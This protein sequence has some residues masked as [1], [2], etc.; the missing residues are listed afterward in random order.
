MAEPGSRNVPFGLGVPSLLLGISAFVLSVV[1]FVLGGFA[2]ASTASLPLGGLGFLLGLG[3]LAVSIMH[4]GH[5]IGF[6]LAGLACNLSALVTALIGI[7]GLGNAHLKT[8]GV[9]PFKHEKALALNQED[10]GPNSGKRGEAVASPAKTK[11]AEVKDPDWIDASNGPFAY[12]DISVKVGMVLVNSVTIKDVLGQQ[13][14]T[15]QKYLGIQLFIGNAGKTKKINYRGWAGVV[16]AGDLTDLL[17]SAGK[18]GGGIGDVIGLS[19]GR[20]AANL[21]DNFGNSYKRIALELGA[22]IPGQIKGDTSIYP[23]SIVEDLL[24]FE[25]PVENVQ[26]LCLELPAAAFGEKGSI[27][28]KIPQSMIRR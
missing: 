5:Q 21:T 12:G 23:G 8:D 20:N 6:P 17:K 10:A 24:V 15:Q 16:N 2:S 3:G 14:D 25:M 22:E 19:G 1:P 26:Y 7:S 27:Y 11:R 18:E 13:T 28:L 9:G 4:R